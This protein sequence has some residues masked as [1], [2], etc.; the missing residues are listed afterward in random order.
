MSHYL[1]ID[2]E[3]VSLVVQIDEN[4][5]SHGSGCGENGALG[6]CLEMDL[7]VPNDGWELGDKR[8]R[9]QGLLYFWPQQLHEQ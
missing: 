2:W 4:V 7:V 6:V 3:A 9:N 1:R 5:L 8:M